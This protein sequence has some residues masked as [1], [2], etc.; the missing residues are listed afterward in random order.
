M[1]HTNGTKFT[2]KG[3]EFTCIDLR[4]HP[5]KYQDDVSYY[6]SK[7]ATMLTSDGRTDIRDWDNAVELNDGDFVW[8]DGKNY[9]VI[10][11]DVG[12]SDG[13]GF[14]TSET[15]KYVKRTLENM[16]EVS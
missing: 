8:I 16:K 13:V 5:N 14:V 12:C 7:R 1:T 9:A 11:K 3:Q 10:E 2:I 4:D 15:F 6:G